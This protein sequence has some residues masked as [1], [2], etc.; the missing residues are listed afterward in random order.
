MKR[1]YSWSVRALALLLLGIF[2]INGAIYLASRRYIYN[3][4][5]QAPQADVV[6]VP[7]AAV[8]SNA[9]PAPIFKDRA[10]A[11]IALYKA[12]KVTKILVSGDNSAVSHNEVNPARRYLIEKGIL[13]QDI[14]LDHAGFDTYSSMYRARAIFGVSSAIITTQSFHLPRAVF[15]A[16]RLGIEAYGVNADLGHML[17]RNYL[18]EVLANEKALLDLVLH[19]TPKYLGDAIPIMGDGREYP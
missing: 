8:L 1:L 19:R 2:I 5:R 18:R 12:G 11:A 10:D 17:L 13:D 4:V 15:I 7:G 16:R 3:E 14:F 6:I 9:V